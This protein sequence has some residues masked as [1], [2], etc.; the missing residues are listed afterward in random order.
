VAGSSGR[1][2]CSTRSTSGRR[3]N[4]R[5][6][7][8]PAPPGAAAAAP[9]CARRAAPARR[10]PDWRSGPSRRRRCGSR[11]GPPRTPRCRSPAGCRSARRHTSSA[12]GSRRRRRAE[13]L[14]VMDAPG[15]VHQRDGAGRR[16]TA[17]ARGRPAPRRCGC[18]AFQVEDAVFGVQSASRPAA[19]MQGVVEGGL[20]APAGISPS[21][22]CA[23]GHRRCRASG[24]VAA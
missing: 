12:P 14:E 10:R 11:G 18:R 3:W 7:S 21:P 4:Q 23:R 8:I 22:G 16:A 13:G 20:D 5:A 15:V 2:G 19:S 24:S 17:S 6:T 9:W 1:A